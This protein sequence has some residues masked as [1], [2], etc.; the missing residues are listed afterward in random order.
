[1][2]M[3]FQSG[4]NRTIRKRITELFI[5]LGS[6]NKDG[7]LM[8]KEVSPFHVETNMHALCVLSITATSTTR[9]FKEITDR[10]PTLLKP[11]HQLQLAI[12]ENF[13]GRKWWDQRRLDFKEARELLQTREELV[14]KVS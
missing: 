3:H 9:Q 13:F 14:N 4:C 7:C 6:K 2:R 12:S 5:K 10:Y 1:M 11:M 8:Q